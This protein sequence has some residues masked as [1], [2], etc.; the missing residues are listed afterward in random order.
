ML[1]RWFAAFVLLP[2]VGY[3]QTAQTPEEQARMD[4]QNAT[5]RGIVSKGPRL[6]YALPIAAGAIAAMWLH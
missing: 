3:A 1:R 2:L 6:P 4:Q 5:L